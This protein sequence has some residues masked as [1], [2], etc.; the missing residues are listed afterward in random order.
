MAVG[1]FWWGAKFSHRAWEQ[2][3]HRASTF[4]RC[5]QGSSLQA[6]KSKPTQNSK[7][8]YTQIC[9]HVNP[10][11]IQ[12]LKGKQK[13]IRAN[14]QG[15]VSFI[16]IYIE[17]EREKRSNHMSG[18]LDSFRVHLDLIPVWFALTCKCIYTLCVH[19]SIIHTPIYNIIYTC[20]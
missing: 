6:Y 18:Q 12:Y 17:R 19:I 1:R 3:P 10:Y 5:H 4:L 15:L 13:H 2:F 14:V 16:L 11:R 20:I 7:K 9:K 8:K